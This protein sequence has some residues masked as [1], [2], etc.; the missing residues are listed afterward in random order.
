[1]LANRPIHKGISKEVRILFLYLFVN[2]KG[3]STRIKIIS[4]LRMR[5]LNANQLSMALEMDYKCISHHLS[6]LEKNNIIKRVG[7]R[8]GATYRISTLTEVNFEIFEEIIDA[9][10]RK[11]N[12]RS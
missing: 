3:G 7:E 11:E 9:H 5:N 1:M 8:Y 12:L 4:L 6:V 10:A 2:S